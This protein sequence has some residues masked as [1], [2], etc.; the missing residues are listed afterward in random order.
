MHLNRCLRHHPC[1]GIFQHVRHRGWW[2][3]QVLGPE[4]LS[5][6][7]GLGQSSRRRLSSQPCW[8]ARYRHAWRV[9]Y[10][11][12]MTAQWFLH[13]LTVHSK[14]K[15][16]IFTKFTALNLSLAFAVSEVE[17]FS[18][19]SGKGWDSKWQIR[20]NSEEHKQTEE[21]RQTDRLRNTEF[22][23]LRLPCALPG[24]SAIA[25]A[26]GAYGHTCAI[27]AEGGVK[28][29]GYNNWGQLGIG[30]IGNLSSPIRTPVEVPGAWFG[31]HTTQ[32]T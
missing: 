25:M 3:G 5:Y 9:C 19:P 10:L 22:S 7:A 23:A 28:C 17:G 12:S 2:R 29:W 24:V 32:P 21:H 27:V 4:K 13:N 20:S 15:M 14:V 16:V 26:V 11:H 31:W 1:H 18:I 8:I 6:S 30:S